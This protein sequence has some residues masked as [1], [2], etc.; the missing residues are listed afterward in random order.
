[1]TGNL[2]SSGRDTDLRMGVVVALALAVIVSVAVIVEHENIEARS[3]VALSA[4][5]PEMVS[6]TPKLVAHHQ[7]GIRATFE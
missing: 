3:K 4:S 6:Q 2:I 1:M 5:E 7:A